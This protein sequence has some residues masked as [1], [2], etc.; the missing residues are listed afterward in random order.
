M[1][2]NPLGK[3]RIVFSAR[4]RR[5]RTTVLFLNYASRDVVQ[6]FTGLLPPFGRLRRLGYQISQFGFTAVK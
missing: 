4:Y 6:T 1:Q 5:K 3:R 2:P